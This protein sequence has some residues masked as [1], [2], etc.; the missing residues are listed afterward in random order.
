MLAK[1]V[2]GGEGRNPQQSPLQ[3]LQ[4]W[5]RK[6]S[7]V[8]GENSK[9]TQTTA[10]KLAYAGLHVEHEGKCLPGK[11]KTHLYLGTEWP[12]I[13]AL[14]FVNRCGLS[15]YIFPTNGM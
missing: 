8:L 15:D 1:S 10:R 3:S 5:S 4:S 6:T 13:N 12:R 2:T 7:T 11:L 9:Y 14:I